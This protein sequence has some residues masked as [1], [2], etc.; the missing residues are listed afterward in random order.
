MTHNNIPPTNIAPPLVS[1]ICAVFNG[2][3]TIEES[4]KSVINQTYSNIE[5]VIIDGGSKDNT[6]DIINKY[7]HKI[8]YFVSEPDKGIYDAM[9]KGI[10]AA[11]GEW[12]FFLGCDDYVHD[13]NVFHNIFKNTTL[14]SFNDIVYGDVLLQHA[15]RR[16]DGEYNSQKVMWQN[17]CHQSIFY[18]KS[19][20]K[21]FGLFSL[22]FP[23]LAD[24][25]FN[26]RWF[27][28]K[29]IRRKYV[30]LV[31]TIYNECGSSGKT[32]DPKFHAAYY[33]LL[34]HNFTLKEYFLFS[35]KKIFHLFKR[36][37]GQ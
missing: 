30:D 29:Q 37:N 8:A 36:K 14:V 27:S 13:E 21:K 24:W 2:G 26:I 33:K 15:N 32:G 35:L 25:E 1:V 20:F 11:R 22:E 19:V 4:I 7:E 28:D 17:I 5:Y 12:L 9:N 34:F 31:I 23:M 16:Y 18:N 3:A 10:Q 6:L